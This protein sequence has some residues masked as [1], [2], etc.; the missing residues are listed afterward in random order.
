MRPLTLLLAL[1][2]IVFLPACATGPFGRAAGASAEVQTDAASYGDFMVA[3]YAA[4]TNDPAAASRHYAA[5]MSTAPESAAVPER[6]VFSALMAGDYPLAA[7]MARR[8]SDAGHESGLVRLALAVD[9]LG[10]GKYEQA[11]ELIEVSD[12]KAFNR[13]VGR[14]LSAWAMVGQRKPGAAQDLLKTNLTGEVRLDNVTLHMLGFVQA[15]AGEDVQAAETFGTL[16]QAGARLAAGA[17]AYARLLAASG[18]PDEAIAVLEQFNSEVGHNAGLEALR[19]E[20][21]AGRKVA[22][23]RL[24][25]RQG[26]ALAVYLPA[27]ALM[28]QTNDDVAAVYF[29]LALALDPDLHPARTLLAQSLTQAGR[30]EQAIRVLREVPPGSPFYAAA[31]GQLARALLQVERPDEALKV[32]AEA[33]AAKPERSLRL[34]LAGLY[35]AQEQ[36]DEAEGILSEIIAEDTA[37]GR[38]DWQALFMRGAARERLGNWTGSDADLWRAMELNPDNANVLNYLGYSWIDRGIRLEEGFDLIRR[39][40]SLEPRSGHIVDSLGWA[41]YR[42]GQYDEAVEHLERAVELLPADPVLNDHL[43]D[44]YWKVGRQVEAGFQWKRVL[45]LDPS[46]EVRAKVEDKLRGGIPVD[47]PSPGA[48]NAP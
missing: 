3:R 5:A 34:Q 45:K 24:T 15:A 43:G 46:P 29:V 28:Y 17:E 35:S 19:A 8:A 12:F 27:S 2:P 36:Y 33:L 7:G 16:W 37:A 6:A 41:H 10:R 44:A 21:A 22:V 32:A 47:P 30:Q 9:S 1:A 38:E 14:G 40:V 39:A 31:R 11:V 25:P 23:Q 48:A 20:I 26:A 42:L 18:K 4:M 13:M